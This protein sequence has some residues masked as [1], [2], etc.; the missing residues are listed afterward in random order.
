MLKLKKDAS[1][2]ITNKL[3]SAKYT[4]LGHTRKTDFY[5]GKTQWWYA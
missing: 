4:L 5:L 1:S 2:T 3:L